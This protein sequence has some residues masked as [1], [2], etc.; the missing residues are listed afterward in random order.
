MGVRG[1]RHL[2]RDVGWLASSSSSSSEDDTNDQGTSNCGC[3]TSIW[4]KVNAS[5]AF[6]GKD[7]SPSLE[8]IPQHSTFLIDG[9]GLAFY[10]H[11]IAYARYL[12]S[13]DTS[14]NGTHNNNNNNNSSSSD[15]CPLSRTIMS[16]QQLIVKALPCVLPLRL[17]RE[18]TKEFV[19]EL[20]NSD[21]SIK[22]IKVFWDGTMRRHKAGTDLKRRAFRKEQESNLEMFCK[23]GSIKKFKKNNR[24]SKHICELKDDFPFSKL[25]LTCVR[26]ALQEDV[27]NP[28]VDMVECTEEADLE[29]ALEAKGKEH[30]FIC[31]LDSDFFFYK[32]INYIPLN[33]ISIQT[34]GIHA[35]IARRSDLANLLGFDNDSRLV[36]LA[37]LMGNDYV[38]SL[39]LDL[40]DEIELNNVQSIVF[41]LQCH[42]DFEVIAKNEEGK[43]AVKFVRSLY[44]FYNLEEFPL[45]TSQPITNKNN[46][47]MKNSTEAR[48]LPQDMSVRD[49]LIRYLETN[50][51][52]T[53]SD[54]NSLFTSDELHAYK[55]SS[56]PMKNLPTLLCRPTY[57]DMELASF[58]ERCISRFYRTS[59]NSL[60]IKATPPDALLNR[61][62]FFSAIASLRENVTEKV[63]TRKSPAEERTPEKVEA[64]RR[65]PID[66]HETEI[67]DDIRNNRVTII[68]GETGYVHACL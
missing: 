41:Y 22:Q 59:S 15:C 33:Q 10:L 64:V 40:P 39:S 29:L 45:E 48:L 65:L 30:T 67:L 1:I 23:H 27:Q 26:H 66:D 57:Q 36:D 54:S 47:P 44:N 2:L 53:D 25:F 34:S 20:K 61:I 6:L 32:D 46:I 35:F 11:S 8:K 49:G 5:D 56:M 12:R 19:S 9:N 4:K 24:K 14:T 3:S 18:V 55:I 60:L 68:H 50:L 21:D 43:A 58:I 38:D 37:L 42:E 63:D 7:D 31:G 16:D 51:D 28:I 17:L 13:L 52:Q 62:D